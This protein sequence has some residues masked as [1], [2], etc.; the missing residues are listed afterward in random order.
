MVSELACIEP[1]TY[2][3]LHVAVTFLVYSYMFLHLVGC[4]PLETVIV[5]LY[6]NGTTNKYTIFKGV[7]QV[8]QQDVQAVITNA[9]VSCKH[10]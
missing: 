1:G 3:R 4:P 2:A 5:A 10:H 9:S 7:A 8:T 6:S